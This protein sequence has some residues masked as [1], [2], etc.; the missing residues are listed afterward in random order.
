MNRE[1][2]WR[3]AEAVFGMS[4]HEWDLFKRIMDKDPVFTTTAERVNALSNLMVIVLVD[5]PKAEGRP[6]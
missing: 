2:A 6:I 1:Q 4:A 3:V 5:K